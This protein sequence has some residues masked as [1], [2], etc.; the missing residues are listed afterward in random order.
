MKKTI[1]GLMIT[2]FFYCALAQ[3][4]AQVNGKKISLKFLKQELEKLPLELQ[5]DFTE[6]Y[7]GFLEELI[8]QELVVQEAIR[9]KL[10]TIKEIKSRIAQNKIMRNNILMDELLNREIRS[11]I[12]VSEEELLKYYKDNQEQMK[13][14]TYQQIKPQIYQ[15]LLNQRQAAAIK[16][17]IADLRRKAI[18]TYNEKWQKSEE[19]KIQNPIKR[20]LKNKLPTMIDF[21]SRTCMP[22]IQMKPIIA[23]LQKEYKDRA[24]ILLLDVDEYTTLTHNYR[25]VVVPTQIFFD[26]SSN[27]I[28]RHSGFFSKDSILIQLKKAG[29]K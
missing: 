9:Q 7:P 12:Q 18:I 25:I 17:Y 10:D 11:Q 23:E 28:F 6:D 20:A 2:S 15:T 14:L 21:G 1:I 27:E 8:N 16:Q 19:A 24:N 13:G 3:T 26:T 5:D 4:I 22:C 29:L